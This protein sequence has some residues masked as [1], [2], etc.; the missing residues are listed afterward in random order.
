M[1][2]FVKYYHLAQLDKI[3]TDSRGISISGSSISSKAVHLALNNHSHI[4]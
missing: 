3:T 1:V 2:N 4:F